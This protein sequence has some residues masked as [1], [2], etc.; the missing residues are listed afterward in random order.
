MVEQVLE[1]CEEK[2]KRNKIYKISNPS[3]KDLKEMVLIIVPF[4]KKILA[5]DFQGD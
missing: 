2:R 3:L 5:R 1:I 4:R